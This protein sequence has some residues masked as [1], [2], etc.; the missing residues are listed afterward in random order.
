VNK[1][2]LWLT[3]KWAR[4]NGREYRTVDSRLQVKERG[5]DWQYLDAHMYNNHR[6]EGR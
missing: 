3:I 5:K 6:E 1:I 4:L 2:M